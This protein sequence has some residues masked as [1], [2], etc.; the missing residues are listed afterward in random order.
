VTAASLLPE[1]SDGAGRVGPTPFARAPRWP[2]GIVERVG[3]LGAAV[4][5]A[6]ASGRPVVLDPFGELAIRNPATRGTGAV[7]VGG[8]TRLLGAA[9]GWIA[10]SL[11]RLD[12]LD[13]VPAWCALMGSDPS[14][15]DPGEMWESVARAV[16]PGVTSDVVGAARLLGLP[17][18]A[19]GEVGVPDHPLVATTVGGSVPPRALDGVVVVDLSSLWAGPL[20]SQ[21]LGRAGATVVKVE[22]AARPDGARRGPR[23]FFDHL[24]AGK[25][26]LVLDLDGAVGRDRLHE[27]LLAADV[28]VEASRPRV[29]EHWGLDPEE[30]MDRSSARAWVSITGYGRSG[31]EAAH[32]AFGD[33]AAV[34]GGLVAFDGDRPSFLA[35]AVADPLSG[36]LAAAAAMAAV[37]S[38][39]RYF[40]DVA[41][42]R[43]AAW[44]AGPERGPAM[45]HR[46]RGRARAAGT[47]EHHDS[48]VVRDARVGG[49]LADVVVADG[50]VEHI[51]FH[52]L[53]EARVFGG[54]RVV[55]AAGADLLPGLH[56][57]HLHLLSLAASLGSFDLAR[58]VRSGDT[59]WDTLGRFARDAPGERGWLRVTGYHESM[60]PL[61]RAVLDGLALGRPV[62]VQHRSGALWVLDSLGARSVGLD[63]ATVAGVERDAAGRV[64]GK[65]FGQDAWLGARIGR[66]APGLGA[67]AGLLHRHGVTGVTDMTPVAEADGLEPIVGAARRGLPLRLVVATG[68]ELAGAPVALGPAE[69][70]P[71]KVYLADHDLPSYR[72]VVDAFRAARRAGRT[73]AVHAVTRE[74][75]ALTLAAW[76]EVGAVA[77]DRLEHGSI[78]ARSE[79]RSLAGL[80]VT[81]VTQPHFIAERGDDY[82]V[83]V[84]AVDQPYLYPFASL[85]AAGIKVGIGTD[86]PFGGFDP[87]AAVSAAATRRTASGRVLGPDERVAPAVALRSFLADPRSPG[88][89]PR[90]LREG[91]PA[92]LCLVEH[93]AAGASRVVATFFGGA[94]VWSADDS[95]AVPARRSAPFSAAPAAR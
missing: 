24:N 39:N 65:V 5:C 59:P 76:N 52:D 33:D 86:A 41:L 20:C 74:A 95:D 40:C 29:W 80:E 21:L 43:T 12:D 89:P 17:A 26:T 10:A 45:W 82:A 13:A 72:D 49:R 19:L 94:L 47:E 62:R 84:P 91:G 31:P 68:P 66:T 36:M 37:T 16:R 30:V 32:V 6:S 34:A 87:W 88:G 44:V 54:D 85:L 28:V 71:V 25:Q 73:V 60:G 92:D 56:D 93:A 53:G 23:A 51:G 78:V 9:D 77:G 35:D 38:G 75:V 61:D 83:D 50:A 18:A 42:A 46:P 79:A 57:H 90:R 63:G 11:A 64:T 70:G 69:I 67:V 8:A 3:R 7:S 4:R 27:L 81:V 2:T 22:S 58:A 55:E 14:E 48:T 1:L 15:V